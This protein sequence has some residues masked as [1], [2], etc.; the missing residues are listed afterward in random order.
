MPSI[1]FVTNKPKWIKKERDLFCYFALHKNQF[2]FLDLKLENVF[3]YTFAD[4]LC[5][6]D[7]RNC[8]AEDSTIIHGAAVAEDS[9][10]SG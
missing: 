6:A 1:Y 3:G 9:F 10:V 5:A 7:C 4:K 2:N 8:V